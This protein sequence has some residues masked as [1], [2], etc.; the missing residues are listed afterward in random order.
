MDINGVNLVSLKD[1][2]PARSKAFLQTEREKKCVKPTEKARKFGKSLK[3]STMM[4]VPV[5][6]HTR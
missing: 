5:G 6:L 1:L 3:C 4:T 2:K